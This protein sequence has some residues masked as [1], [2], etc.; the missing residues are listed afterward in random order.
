MESISERRGL[1]GLSVASLLE[2]F[3][4]LGRD[5]LETPLGTRALN[6]RVLFPDMGLK[7]QL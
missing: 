5:V 3:T 6:A 2:R 1:P 7:C 4:A